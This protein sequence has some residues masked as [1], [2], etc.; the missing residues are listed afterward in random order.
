MKNLKLISMITVLMT[1]SLLS[2]AQVQFGVTGGI[3]F[4]KTNFKV[5]DLTPGTN[6]KFSKATGAELG[7]FT[8]IP[9]GFIYVK[10]MA[11][12]SFLRGTVTGGTDNVNESDDFNMSTIEVPVLV[13]LQLLPFL[14]IEGGPSWN[15]LMDHSENV[16]GVNLSF[17]RHSVGYR[18]G[19]VLDLGT[20]G[21]FGHYGG[22]LTNNEGR[23][24]E[25]QRPSRIIV[26]VKLNLSN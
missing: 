23:Q 12:V 17:N 2:E 8:R 7:I 15:Y 5:S 25:L 22:I 14:S 4:K 18:A 11:N 24:V 16:N 3:S 21:I 19:A 26:G 1:S 10:P 6:L 13:G 20:L 9:A